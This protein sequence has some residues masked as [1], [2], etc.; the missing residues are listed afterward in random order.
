MRSEFGFH[1]IL[2]YIRVGSDAN[3]CTHCKKVQNAIMGKIR[4]Q[5]RFQLLTIKWTVLQTIRC[6]HGKQSKI[7]TSNNDQIVVSVSNDG[8]ILVRLRKCFKQLLKSFT[9]TPLDAQLGP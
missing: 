8:D 6:L 4:T 3:M 1:V 2:L 9:L 7:N 5:T